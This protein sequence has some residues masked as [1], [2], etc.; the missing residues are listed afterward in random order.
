MTELCCP[1]C[2]STQVT[3]GEISTYYV[4][5]GEFF[6]HSVKSH[7][8]DAPASCTKCWWTGERKDLV[9]KEGV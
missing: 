5:T 9:E 1:N 3:V 8:S 2:R 4:N 6:C 7:D